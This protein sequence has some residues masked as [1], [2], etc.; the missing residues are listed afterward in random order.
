LP[1]ENRGKFSG[2]RMI[3]WIAIPMVIDRLMAHP[4]LRHPHRTERAGRLHPVP[5]LPGDR[6]HRAVSLIPLMFIEEGTIQ[7]TVILRCLSPQQIRARS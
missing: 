1:E 5:I 6:G 2:V 4:E 7:V 3:F